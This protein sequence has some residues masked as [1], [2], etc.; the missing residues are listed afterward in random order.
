M[1]SQALETRVENLE[2]RVTMLEEL[3]ARIDRIESQIVQLRTEMRDGFSA[4]RDEIRTTNEHTV[5]TLTEAIEVARRETRVLFEEALARIA[6]LDEAR[7][8]GN[9]PRKPRKK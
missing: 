6:V 9:G 3:P 1:R 5:R 7:G 8:N 4:M 2:K